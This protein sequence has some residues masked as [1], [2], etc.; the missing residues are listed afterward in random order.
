MESENSSQ[1]AVSSVSLRE[2]VRESGSLSRYHYI[3]NAPQERFSRPLSLIFPLKLLFNKGWNQD[4]RK[5]LLLQLKTPTHWQKKR[6]KTTTNAWR[7]SYITLEKK[8]TYAVH[9]YAHNK[10]KTNSYWNCRTFVPQK[11]VSI[12]TH[13]FPRHCIEITTKL[14]S[15]K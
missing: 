14:G 8:N 5:L 11:S 3:L 4:S 9:I 6:E 1:Y 7:P 15:F 2:W 10:L 13:V 12:S